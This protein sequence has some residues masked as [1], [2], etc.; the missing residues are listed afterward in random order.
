MPKLKRLLPLSVLFLSVAC[1][2]EKL[3]LVLDDA[4]VISEVCSVVTE[5]DTPTAPITFTITDEDVSLREVE[6]VLTAA[7]TA[8]VPEDG[9][10]LEQDGNT[11]TDNRQY[12]RQPWRSMATSWSQSITS[13]R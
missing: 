5:E 8:L 1:A 9:M 7:D 3:V 10:V 4:P 6:V 2:Q 12:G 13:C 11:F